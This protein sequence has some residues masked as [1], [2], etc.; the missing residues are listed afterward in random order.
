MYFPRNW[1][2][3]SILSKLRNFR[4]WG[5][6]NPQI[7]LPRYAIGWTDN[8]IAGIDWSQSF[9]KRHKNLTLRKP[10]N[11]SLF[12]ASAFSKANL[13]EFFASFVLSLTSWKF[14]HYRVY[15][16]DETRVSQLGTTQVGQAVSGERGTVITAFNIINKEQIKVKVIL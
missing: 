13:T 15:E 2:L 1:E 10:E 14:T 7:P 9:M 3:G 6:L 4:G 5:V 8:K 12:R 16:M 11:K